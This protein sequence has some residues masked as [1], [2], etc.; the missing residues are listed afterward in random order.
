VGCGSSANV[1]TDCSK[2]E[3]SLQP[4]IVLSKATKDIVPS[5]PLILETTIIGG[6][7]LDF[8]SE[9]QPDGLTK[10]KPCCLLSWRGAAHIIEMMSNSR[11]M[12]VW[13]QTMNLEYD[14][15]VDG[16]SLSIEVFVPPTDAQ[17]MQ[18]HLG[19]VV[20]DLALIRD[21]GKAY[22]NWIPLN[23][24]SHAEVGVRIFPRGNLSLLP[25][26][27]EQQRRK[28]H[29]IS[30]EIVS[31]NTVTVTI[32]SGRGL[33]GTDTSVPLMDTYCVLKWRNMW[34][35]TVVVTQSS[36][37]LWN[38]SIDLPFSPDKDASEFEIVL[39]SRIDTQGTSDNDLVLGRV[40]P[41]F[42]LVIAGGKPDERWH[43]WNGEGA[44]GEVKI[45]VLLHFVK[46]QTVEHIPGFV[47]T[48]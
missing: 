17:A 47:S 18:R 29:T 8:N 36:D 13:E 38:E 9:L 12:V 33:R 28:S 25:F 39:K 15:A 27:A 23:G 26:I 20:V 6:K 41:S 21:D 11:A 34:Y 2:D 4:N 22:S 31:A 35:P 14:P 46:G 24:S 3:K 30:N 7:G 43:R 19:T 42:R 40:T 10:E 45:R 32:L 37:P 44:K 16:G 5:G 48:K 1:R